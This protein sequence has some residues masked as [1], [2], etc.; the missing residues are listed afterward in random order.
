M[1]AI[2]RLV[3]ELSKLPGIGEKTATRLAYYIAREDAVSATSL[4]KA[5]TDIKEKIRFCPGCL[6]LTEGINCPICSDTRRDKTTVCVVEEPQDAL[7]IEKTGSFKG[8]Y[9]VLHGAISPLDGI[10]PDDIKINEL[11]SRIKN[12]HIKE[13]IIA[14]NPTT[15]G[16]AT[17]L[18]IARL[19]KPL[20]VKLSR[21][22]FGVP[23]GGDIEYIDKSTLAKSI[24]G[25]MGFSS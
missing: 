24:E 12:S 14:T 1:T 10:G 11:I 18:Y 15:S 25:R 21:I 8:L 2:E 3:K 17:S 19:L 22:A 20:G 7:A 16:E 9:H 13:L 23:F 4:A 6:N 5:I